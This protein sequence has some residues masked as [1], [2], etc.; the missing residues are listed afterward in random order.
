MYSFGAHIWNS[1]NGRVGMYLNGSEKHRFY[2]LDDD[3][4]NRQMNFMVSQLLDVGDVITFEN[5]DS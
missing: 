5:H 2:Q 3:K 4:S 1:E